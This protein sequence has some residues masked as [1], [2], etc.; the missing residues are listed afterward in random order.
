MSA[1]A[2]SLLHPMAT[3]SVSFDSLLSELN[4]AIGNL[5]DPRKPSNASN[6]T[7]QDTVLGAFGC[8]FMQS[9]SFLDYQRQLDSRNGRNNAQ[10]L[11][12]LKTIPSVAQIRNI[13]DQIA[14]QGLFQVFVN[15]YRVLHQ[16]VALLVKHTI[17]PTRCAMR[18]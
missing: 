17:I 5:D 8:F 6:Y 2:S 4:G 13:L 14:A 16:Q 18:T 11:F 15:I 12:G 1:T 9:A 3:A 7:I 10:S